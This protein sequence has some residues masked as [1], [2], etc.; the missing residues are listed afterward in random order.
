VVIQQAAYLIVKYGHRPN[1]QDATEI[2]TRS[3]QDFG[4]GSKKQQLAPQG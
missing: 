2:A 4:R 3:R 1:G